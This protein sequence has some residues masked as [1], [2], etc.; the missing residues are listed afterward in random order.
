MTV[1]QEVGSNEVGTP[2]ITFT[3]AAKDRILQVLKGKGIE[4]QRLRVGIHG[5]GPSGFQYGMTFEEAGQEALDDTV[6]DVGAFEVLLDSN[7]ATHIHGSS[8]DYSE[9]GG[10]GGFQIENP[11]P[12][13]DDPRAQQ[14]QELFDS[15]V[16]PAIAN[17]GGYVQLID[18]KDNT[19]YVVLGGGCQGCGMVDVTLKQG[20]EVMIREAMPEIEQ[21]VD[22]T[23]HAGGSNPYYQPAKG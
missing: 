4:G 2:L 22:T 16:N 12:L 1:S 13:W 8:V 15:Q 19:V 23:D 21:V 18:V 9:S 7:A 11:N 3:D 5:R 10:A 17:H 6:V 20:I 14:I